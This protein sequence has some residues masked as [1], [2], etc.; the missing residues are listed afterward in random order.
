MD[1]IT[2][3]TGGI[4]VGQAA[5]DGYLPWKRTIPFAML[6]AWIPDIDNFIGFLG[7][8]AY[9][10]HHR[11][12]THS[13][14]GGLAVALLLV[15]AAKAFNRT[16]PAWRVLTVAYVAF[17]VH[18]FLDAITSYGTQIYLPFSS[19]RA[20]FPV[21]FIIDPFFTLTLIIFAVLAW[22]APPKRRFFA[23]VGLAWMLLYPISNATLRSNVTSL[24]SRMLVSQGVEFQRVHVLPDAFTPL[25]WKVI[26]ED[27]QSYRMTSVSLLPG[28][29]M[30]GFKTYRKV[31]PALLDSLAEQSEF[32]TVY[33]W[34][35]EYMAM[36]EA[37]NEKPGQGGHTIILHDLR[38]QLMTP[39]VSKLLPKRQAPFGLRAELDDQDRLLRAVYLQGSG[40]TVFPVSQ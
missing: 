33:R 29:G 5:Q 18:I 2:H 37:P 1:P 4:L 38:F 34:F 12:I 3:I 28:R 19:A 14:V 16:L 35:N 25:W 24:Y 32:I 30:E 10:L 31:D 17:L 7:P 15:L 23:V 36:E 39:P 13:F 20:Q 6:A 40:T 26:V 9:L 27:E 21:V 11:G 8:Q 22:L